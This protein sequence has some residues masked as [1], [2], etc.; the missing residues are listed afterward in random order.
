MKYS[1]L[2]DYNLKKIIRFFCADVD[3]TKASILLEFNRKTINR[4]YLMF[5]EVYFYQAD[6]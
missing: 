2:S 6:C 4:S 3:A 1:K 5:S